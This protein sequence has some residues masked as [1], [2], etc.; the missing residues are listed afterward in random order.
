MHH[1]KGNFGA[2]WYVKE[3]THGGG[4]RLKRMA[5]L[6]N[7]FTEKLTPES[8]SKVEQKRTGPNEQD[9]HIP[10]PEYLSKGANHVTARNTRR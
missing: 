3:T 1:T 9:P 10:R 4:G 7:L 2:L 6:R 8:Y 5:G